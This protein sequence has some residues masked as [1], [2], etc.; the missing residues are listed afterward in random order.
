MTYLE[1]K[2]N[3]LHDITLSFSEETSVTLRSFTKNNDIQLDGLIIME[4][5]ANI[6]PTLY[7]NHY[8]KELDNGTSY[9]DLLN[10][11]KQDYHSFKPK[12]NFDVSFFTDYEKAKSHIVYKII[13]YEKNM[14]LLEDVPHIHYMDLA[15][16]FYYLFIDDCRCNTGTVLIHHEHLKCWGI[17][18]RELMEKATQNTQMMLPAQVYNLQDMLSD[19]IGDDDE[20]KEILSP[21]QPQIPM[22]VLTN[23]EKFN[24]A[25]V[26]LYPDVL[27]DLSMK[28]GANLYIIPSSVHEIII[29]PESDAKSKYLLNEMVQDVNENQVPEDEIL[30]DHVY[31]YSL[32]TNQVTF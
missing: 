29:I 30:S 16:V 9:A 22:Y 32:D 26:I 17:S 25:G 12:S 20:L 14:D 4:E 31:Y 18:V 19:M 7:L 21:E 1:F 5:D 24:G 15:I 3:V 2:E 11:I 10:K 8:Y 6:A 27:K 23:S 13:N 28:L